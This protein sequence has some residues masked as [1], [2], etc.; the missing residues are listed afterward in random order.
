ML[1]HYALLVLPSPILEGKL[2]ETRDVIDSRA[3]DRRHGSMT[4]E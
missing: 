1:P 4:V 3:P 2:D